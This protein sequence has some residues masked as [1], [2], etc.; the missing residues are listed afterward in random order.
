MPIQ[1]KLSSTMRRWLANSTAPYRIDLLHNY[2]PGFE[3]G[4]I[5]IVDVDP[6]VTATA[7]TIA[8]SRKRFL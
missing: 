7:V 4:G 8:Q 1:V 6:S 2:G 3:N 5:M